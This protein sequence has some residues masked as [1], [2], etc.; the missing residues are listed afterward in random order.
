MRPHEAD[1]ALGPVADLWP[2]LAGLGE[3]RW[4][5]ASAAADG[6][7]TGP[8]LAGLRAAAE[9]GMVGG[10]ADWFAV[11]ALFRHPLGLPI[12]HTAIIPENKDRIADAMAELGMKEG[13]DVCLEMSGHGSA[14]REAIDTM[15]HGGA[16][17]MLGL[18]GQGYEVDWGKVITHMLTLQGIYG[19]EMFE[20]WYAMS[21]LLQSGLDISGVITD[22]VPYA[23]WP[24]AFAAAR[25]GDS[26][27]VIMTWR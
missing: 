10:L 1:L 3:R 9:A 25:D 6:R 24:T 20:T 7:M 17:A 12:P 26:G 15:N 22:R 2:D 11:T 19:R 27:K 23:D 4:V 8:D 14:V 16:I 13:F 21:V 18:P 5:L